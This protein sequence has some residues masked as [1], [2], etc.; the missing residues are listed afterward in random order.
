MSYQHL[1]VMLNEAFKKYEDKIALIAPDFQCTYKELQE[2]ATLISKNLINRG[3]LENEPVIV[4]TDNQPEDIINIVSVILS[5][6]IVVPLDKNSPK[7]SID[8][9]FSS[10][11]ARFMLGEP[12]HIDSKDFSNSNIGFRIR[13]KEK[14]VQENFDYLSGAAIIVFT[15]GTTGAP[16]GVVMSHKGYC[17]K[18]ERINSLIPFDDNDIVALTLKLTFSFGQWVSLISLWCGASIYLFP[19]FISENV[20]QL[21][22]KHQVTKFPIVPSMM[23]LILQQETSEEVFS[24]KNILF[25]AGGEVLPEHTG[26]KFLE[27]FPQSDMCDIYGLTETNSADFILMPGEYDKY[28]NSIGKPTPGV[29]Y[30]IV[31]SDGSLA[32]IMETGDLWIKTEHIM[33][34]YLDSPYLTSK[35]FE[36]D[37]F[38]TGDLAYQRKDGCVSICGRLKDEINRGGNKISPAEI[39]G[40]Y[41]KFP[42]IRLAACIAISDVVY[43]EKTMLVYESFRDIN[44]EALISFGQNYLAKYKI[45]DVFKRVD[46]IPLGKTGKLDRSA[47]RLKYYERK[48]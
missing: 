39:E 40:I 25:I 12:N 26:K 35:A 24:N 8:I 6:G 38:K 14:F 23:R 11:K 33:L 18:L 13:Q 15:S 10:T 27:K 20:L 41:V 46:A 5:H 21:L 19:K 44:E 29:E 43:G 9:I 47:L 22:S 48:N 36:E 37:F 31:R 42:D 34:F 4:V 17:K 28:S 30:K 1:S 3:L 2:K 7:N 45:P 32:K 16:K